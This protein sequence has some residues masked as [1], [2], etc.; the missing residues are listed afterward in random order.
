[1]FRNARLLTVLLIAGVCCS[2]CSDPIP[3]REER[4]PVIESP[5]PTPENTG[6]VDQATL[7]R[8]VAEVTKRVDGAVAEFYKPEPSLL[9]RLFGGGETAGQMGKQE[10]VKRTILEKEYRL[11]G[12]RR[13]VPYATILEMSRPN[14][15][16]G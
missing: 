6:P 8:E 4:L 3:P 15:P 13:G 14:G 12:G 16:C 1:M 5:P 7:C 9:R 2:A 11:L 10:S